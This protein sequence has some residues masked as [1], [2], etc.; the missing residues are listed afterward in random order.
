MNMV[1]LMDCAHKPM[2][3]PKNARPM[4]LA[5]ALF[6]GILLACPDG[7]HA[8]TDDLASVECN[9]QS[10]RLNFGTLARYRPLLVQGE[11]EVTVTCQNLSQEVRTV[12]ISVAF[13]RNGSHTALLQSGHD[14]LYVDFFLDAQLV[15][16]WGDGSN[17]G[18]ALQVILKLGPG[19]RKL[20]HLPVHALLQNRRDARAGEYLVQVPIQMTTV[21][22]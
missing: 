6:V 19:E 12:D 17:G 4:G 7:V 11:G 13:S 2:G 3:V 18:Q 10:T 20:L 16:F 22:R 1:D 8:G 21:P 14:A 5:L 15:Q 9:L